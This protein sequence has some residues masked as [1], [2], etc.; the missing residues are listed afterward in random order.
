[1]S[2]ASS[3]TTSSPAQSK[4]FQSAFAN[5]ESNYGFAGSAP[6]PAPKNTTPRSRTSLVT[7]V[8]SRAPLHAPKDFQ[9]AFADLQSTYGLAG[10]PSTVPRA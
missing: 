8:S 5:L 9:S 3:F 10:P 7:A 6:S 2:S 1:M 4:D